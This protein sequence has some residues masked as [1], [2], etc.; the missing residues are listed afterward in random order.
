MEESVSQTKL[1]P[2]VLSLFR[3][4]VGALF[5]CHGAAT[6][7]GVLGGTGAGTAAPV[8]AW[9]G[10]WAGLIQLVCGA[11]VA[12]GLGTRVAALLGSGSMAYAYFSVHQE[13]ALLPIQNGGEA[14]IMFCWTLLVIALTGPGVWAL[15]P[16]LARIRRVPDRTPQPAE[17]VAEGAAG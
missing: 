11:L 8:G 12:L 10:W 9:P 17:P 5:V 7:F 2:Y 4:I 14:S 16:L 6:V 15:D 13:K 3:V 1:W